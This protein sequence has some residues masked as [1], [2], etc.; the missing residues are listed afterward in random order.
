MKAKVIRVGDTVKVITSSFVKRVGYPLVW[1]DLLEEVTNDPRTEQ[2]WDILTAPA[3]SI[4]KSKKTA[5]DELFTLL[6]AEK[7]PHGF[8]RVIAQLRVEERR[9][10]GNERSLHYFETKPANHISIAS[11]GCA[12]Y[13]GY[14]LE[15]IGKKL[16]KTG[17]R[18]APSSG[19]S[20]YLETEDWFDSGGLDDCKT[21]ILLNTDV[22]WIEA[23]NVELAKR[24]PG[25]TD[26]YPANSKRGIRRAARART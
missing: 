11:I 9:Y 20:G 18:I 25:S 15:V 16:A 24:A 13:T 22:G 17:T 14:N 8:L 6:E 1:T 4:P 19:T 2:A 10:G 21:H 26:E 12:D 5:V 23:V 7:F 3:G